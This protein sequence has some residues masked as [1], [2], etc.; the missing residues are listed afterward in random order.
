MITMDPGTVNTKMLLAGWGVPHLV[1]RL[2]WGQCGIEVEDAT[3]T[4]YL[5]ASDKY[6]DTKTVQYFEHQ[7]KTKQAAQVYE[8]DRCHELVDY[9]L[10]ITQLQLIWDSKCSLRVWGSDVRNR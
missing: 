10:K 7:E 9:L 1:I 2:R 8:K 6:I 3:D 4:Y 5:S